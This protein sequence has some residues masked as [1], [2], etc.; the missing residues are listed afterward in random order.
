ME[1]N[2][3]VKLARKSLKGTSIG[4]AFGESF[5][6]ETDQVLNYI[7]QR[8]VPDTSWDFTDDT[9]MSIAVFEELER[10]GGIDQDRLVQAFIRNHDLDVNRGYGATARR[11]LREIGQGGNWKTISSNVFEGMGSM[12]NGSS[13]RANTIGAYYFDQIGLVKELAIK[14]SEVTHMHQEAI[15]GAV[16]VAVAT[17]LSTQI[18]LNKMA[19]TPERFIE[20]VYKETPDSDLKSKLNKSLS[21][22]ES[23]SIDTLRSILGNGTKILATDTVPFAIWCAAYHLKDFES[24]LWKTV[25]ALGDRDTLCAIVGGI[26]IMSADDSSIPKEWSSSVED[27]ETSPFRQHGLVKGV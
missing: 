22:P 9:V 23:Y 7:N 3:R 14:S 12:G 5:F 10:S 4:D 6:G 26:V 20:I 27:I 21:I 18:G 24:A 16:A 13:M 2:S 25:S 15:S 1:V 19:L 8:E 17:T 11:I